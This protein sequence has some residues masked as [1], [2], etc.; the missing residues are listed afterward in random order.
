M[1]RKTAPAN[2]AA[3]GILLEPS[4][5]GLLF[6]IT[7]AVYRTMISGGRTTTTG[8]GTMTSWRLSYLASPR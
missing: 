2:L 7:G 8:S 4:S 3:S 1:A 5:T 6:L